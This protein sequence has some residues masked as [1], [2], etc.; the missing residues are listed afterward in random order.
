MRI[1]RIR[2]YPGLND[3]LPAPVYSNTVLLN[4]GNSFRIQ[5]LV[6]SKGWTDLTNNMYY[7]WIEQPA[8]QP[9]SRVDKWLNI[10][11]GPSSM[12]RLLGGYSTPSSIKFYTSTIST[13]QAAGTDLG[14]EADMCRMTI[15]GPNA[16]L[17][18]NNRL[19]APTSGNSYG[20]LP[21]HTGTTALKDSTTLFLGKSDNLWGMAMGTLYSGYYGSY[22]QTTYKNTDGGRENNGSYPLLLQPNGGD[23]G[24][25]TASPRSKLD[26]NG[27]IYVGTWSADG[28]T[29]MFGVDPNWGMKFA[30]PETSK[31]YLRLS[32]SG[33]NTGNN[34][35]I[36]FWDTT[37]QTAKMFI[38]AAGN[39]GIGTD[40]PDKK[41]HI[42]DNDSTAIVKITRNWIDSNGLPGSASIYLGANNGWGNI[43]SNTVLSLKAGDTSNDAKTYTSPQLFLD[44]NGKVG[45]GTSSP[46]HRLHVY[47]DTVIQSGIYGGSG[48]LRIVAQNNTTCHFFH[49][50]NEDVYIRSG[51]S[52]GKLILQD[53]GGN[54]G[55]WN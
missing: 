8:G 25:G 27:S 7:K 41:F 20:E 18:V 31:Y 9:V 43:T 2:G 33:E 6:Q 45:I 55:I 11:P 16:I 4:I 32:F 54:V 49:G 35:G 44:T 48:T 1:E 29:Y 28:S 42:E 50:A 10:V 38:N 26:V 47:G 23:V 13:N 3:G 19:Q 51:N 34:R 30:R 15:G 12:I 24:I 21:A 46:Q 39:V 52:N 17:L 5:Q 22:I 40:S 37:S 14:T 53:L 36:Q